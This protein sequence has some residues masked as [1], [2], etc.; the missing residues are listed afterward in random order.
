MKKNGKLYIAIENRL[1]MKYFAG[2]NE[3]HIGKPF[4]GIEG[5][6]N[7]NKVRTFTYS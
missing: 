2:Y 4:I 6:D 3:D 7:K 1:G 5:Y